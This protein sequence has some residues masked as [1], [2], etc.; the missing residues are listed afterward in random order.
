MAE[1]QHFIDFETHCPLGVLTRII[2]TVR[3]KLKEITRA[4]QI[5]RRRTEKHLIDTLIHKRAH[6]TSLNTPESLEE[7]EDA[8]TQLNLH[9]TQRATTTAENSYV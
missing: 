8:R 9:Q 5:A 7:L 2:I 4:N 3:S 1:L 6:Y